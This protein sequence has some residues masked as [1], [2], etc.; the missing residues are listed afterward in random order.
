MRDIRSR[1]NGAS[2]SQQGISLLDV[3]GGNSPGYSAKMYAKPSQMAGMSGAALLGGLGLAGP[4]PGLS[5]GRARGFHVHMEQLVLLAKRNLQGSDKSNPALLTVCVAGA[6]FLIA[7]RV[8]VV[9]A[10]V[11]LCCFA[12]FLFATWLA[13]WVLDKDEGTTE[14]REISDAIRQGADGFFKVQYGLI[15]K[16]WFGCAAVIFVI[17]FFRA[18]TARQVAAG[19]TPT[20]FAV[21]S[22]SQ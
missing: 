22:I 13:T 2:N 17:Y 4:G 5:G 16:L 9:V 12:S 10:F 8:S 11:L 19:F 3:E 15:G 21:V 18:L 20:S 6:I 1:E 7:C 14:M